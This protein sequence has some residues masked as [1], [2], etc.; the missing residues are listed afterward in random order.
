MEEGFLF[1]GND[2]FVVI[3]SHFYAESRLSIPLRV[4]DFCLKWLN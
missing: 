3:P 4:K 2:L 1:I